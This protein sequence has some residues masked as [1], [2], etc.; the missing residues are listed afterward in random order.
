MTLAL[1]D[2]RD[3]DTPAL[4]APARALPRKVAR[5]DDAGPR[6]QWRGPHEFVWR[7]VPVTI[8]TLPRELDGLR[9]LHLSDFHTRRYWPR[10]Y[11]ALLDGIAADPPDLILF[12]G[13]FVESRHNQLPAVPHVRR[14]VEGFHARLGVFGILGNHDLYH[15]APHLDGTKMELIEHDRRFIPLQNAGIEV[16]GLPGVHP[17]DLDPSFLR[18]LPPR[19]ARTVRIVMSHYPDHFTR[20]RHLQP[21]LF[22]CGHTHGGQVCLPG[23]VALITHSKLPRPLCRGTHQVDQTW[24]VINHGLG[25][26]GLPLRVMCPA[27]VV[28]LTLTSG[29]VM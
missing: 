26:S 24:L 6:I 13:D 1:V 14:L 5:D 15:F 18:S 23:G 12:T 29:H 9:I 10:A 19:A 7:H 21:D 16:I 28:E 8:E 22:L 4:A 27:E 17:N 20:T 3:D 11:D 2:R 25:F